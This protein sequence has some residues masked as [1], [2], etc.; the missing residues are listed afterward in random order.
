ME[1]RIKKVPIKKTKNRNI[2]KLV[3]LVTVVNRSK[4]TY[5]VDLLEQFEINMQTTIL[6][7]GTANSEMLNLLGLIETDK[8]VI[9]SLV[10]EEKVKEISDVLQEKFDKIKN[11]KG[12]SFTI[13]LKSIIGISIY[14]F[15]CNNKSSLG[16]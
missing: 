4:G 2:K 6:G 9:L 1:K 14:Q 15:L 7:K 12:I 10:K 13:P 5:Y 3:L 8:V 11:G 16:G